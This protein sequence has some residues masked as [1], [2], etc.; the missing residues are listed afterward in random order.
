MVDVIGRPME[1]LP[2]KHQLEGL[3]PVAESKNFAFAAPFHAV[4]TIERPVAVDAK[5]EFKIRLSG[6]LFGSPFL[7]ERHD[8]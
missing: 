1:F 6:V 3:P 7:L 2:A 5:R 4:S 8:Q